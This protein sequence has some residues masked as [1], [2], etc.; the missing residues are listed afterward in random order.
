MRRSQSSSSWRV[1]SGHEQTSAAAQRVLEQGGNAADA[2]VAAA[3]AA[4]V[5]EPLLCSLGGGG[6]A[7]V[8]SAGRAPLALDFFTQTPRR[9]R[10]GELDFYPI[11]G[12]FGTDT[13]EFHIG[14]ASIA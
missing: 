12:N 3:V 8:Q 9:R 4:S 13:Q 1:A 7:L 5:A 14:M 11:I 2:V 10:Q 6:H